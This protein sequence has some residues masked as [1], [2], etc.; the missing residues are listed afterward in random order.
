M[1]YLLTELYWTA[2]DP[3]LLFWFCII[4]CISGGF[5]ILLLSYILDHY[6]IILWLFTTLNTDRIHCCYCSLHKGMLR[7]FLLQL[8]SL[9]FDVFILADPVVLRSNEEIKPLEFIGINSFQIAPIKGAFIFMSLA[10]FLLSL[11]LQYRL[12]FHPNPILIPLNIFY[13]F[14]RGRVDF[15]TLY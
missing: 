5:F 1:V 7:I 6:Y 12:V 11:V 2:A 9:A 4:S 13:F 10:Q 3:H 8:L 14:I 15:S